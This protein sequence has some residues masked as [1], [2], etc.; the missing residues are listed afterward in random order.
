MSDRITLATVARHVGVSRA[1]VS[2]AYNRPDQ[3]SAALRERILAAAA[4][5]GYPGPDPRASALRSGRVGAVGLIEK[6]LPVALTDPAS[7]LML[8]G[9]AR[10]CDDA[11]VAL[12]LIPFRREDTFHDVVRTAVVDGFVAHCDALDDE[13]RAIIDD[14]RLPVVVLDGS[15]RAGDASIGIDEEAGAA[16]A[17]DHLIGLGHRRLAIVAFAAHTDIELGRTVNERRL[18][19]YHRGV[20]DAGLDPDDVEL[21]DG[22]AYDRAATCA[23]V[24]ERLAR[25]DRPTG[26]VAMSDEMA[27]ATVEAATSL[28]L[29]VPQDLSVVGFD[30]TPTAVSTRPALTTVHQALADK[31]AAAVALLLLGVNDGDE[32]PSI[33]L[34]VELVIR[35]STGPAPAP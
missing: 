16:A 25:P 29:R 34:P 19:G 24:R 20:T 14:R 12:V 1:T 22:D 28:G 5:L 33:T 2:N 35:D 7:L 3:L 27:A 8:S 31:G 9:V 18:V 26:I 6:S 11:G 10:A 17:I 23:V 15:P 13:R 21:L 32:T 4:E 30:D